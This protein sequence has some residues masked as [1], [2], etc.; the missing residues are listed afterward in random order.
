MDNM[1]K[2]IIFLLLGFAIFTTSKSSAQTYF[3][4]A[5]GL[6]GGFGLLGAATYKKYVNASDAVEAIVGLNDGFLN[7]RGAYQRH[8]SITDGFDWYVGG[9]ASLAIFD[10]NIGIGVQGYL[11]LQYVFDDIPLNLTI[12]WVPSFVGG[13]FAPNGG[14]LGIR[15]ILD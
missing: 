13:T 8:I 12:D 5:V 7:V 6:R 2:K 3:D 11:G 4:H 1:K 14:N 10:G 9:G 15:Y